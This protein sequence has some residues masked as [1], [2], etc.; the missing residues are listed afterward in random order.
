MS[1]RG[2]AVTVLVNPSARQAHPRLWRSAMRVLEDECA[3]TM[4]APATGQG[5]SDA[6]RRAVDDGTAAV[7]VVGGDG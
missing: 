2:S 3:V 1:L 4:L 7:V 5:M 6:A